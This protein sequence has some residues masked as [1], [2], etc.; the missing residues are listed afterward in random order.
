MMLKA[1]ANDRHHIA[2]CHNEFRGSL[3]ITGGI[4]EVKSA[5]QAEL[6]D[7]AKNG[8]QKCFE[9]IY[10][11]CRKCAVAQESYF[12]GGCVSSL[13]G[14]SYR[15]SPET[16][17]S[18]YV[19]KEHMKEY[20][21]LFTYLTGVLCMKFCLHTI[22]QWDSPVA[23]PHSTHHDP[24]NITDS[25]CFPFMQFCCIPWQRMYDNLGLT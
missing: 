11:R 7:K 20:E 10:K 16:F 25:T 22:H 4:N 8:F 23:L 5:L 19:Y 12:E 6:K 15:L 1:T 2:L 17:E 24:I 13:T 14:L 21:V 9:E 18:Y 3:P